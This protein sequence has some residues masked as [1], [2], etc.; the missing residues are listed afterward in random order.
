[1]TGWQVRYSL[2]ADM[3]SFAAPHSMFRRGAGNGPSGAISV[4]E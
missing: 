1:L 2:T 3:A 4:P